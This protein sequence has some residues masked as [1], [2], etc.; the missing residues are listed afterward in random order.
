MIDLNDLITVLSR[1]PGVGRKSAARISYYLIKNKNNAIELSNIIKNAVENIKN[2][3]VCGNF[4][5]NDP[6]FFCSAQDRDNSILCIVEDPKDLLAI[7]ETALFRGRYH[8]LMGSINPLEGITPDKLRIKELL[9]RIEKEKFSEILIAT[10]PTIEGEATFL[11]LQ[12][13]LLNYDTKIS[14]LATGIPMG[15]SL[16]YADKLTLSKAIQSKRYI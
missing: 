1:L 14:R 10:N 11:Y 2:C 9:A 16:E 8:V 5:I 7:E 6:C 4:T 15:G 3:S 12:S 13:K